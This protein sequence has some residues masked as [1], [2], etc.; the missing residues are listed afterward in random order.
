MFSHFNS[1]VTFTVHL[2]DVIF[3]NIRGTISIKLPVCSVSQSK[4]IKNHS[5]SINTSK[6]WDMIDDWNINNLAKI[7]VY[8]VFHSRVYSEKCFTQIYRALY[9][10]AML[11]PFR[12]APTWQPH[13]NRNFCHWVLLL[14]R[15]IITLEF[16]HIESNNSSIARIVQSAKTWA[17]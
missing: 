1:C 16:R 14:K 10:D 3:Q 15:N 6:I 13:N 2:A 9:G 7:L 5:H 11:V 17:I 8:A 4:E 12:E